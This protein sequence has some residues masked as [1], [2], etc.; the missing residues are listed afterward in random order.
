MLA[1]RDPESVLDAVLCWLGLCV[2]EA[3]RVSDA[4]PETDPVP[5]GLAL[6]DSDLV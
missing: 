1:V 2:N 6:G 5:A 4:L 3:V